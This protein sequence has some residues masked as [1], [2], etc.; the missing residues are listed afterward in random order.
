MVHGHEP[1]RFTEF[2]RRYLAELRDAGHH[3]AAEHL[4][5]LATHNKLMLLADTKDVDHS[6]VLFSPSG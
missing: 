4:H 5:D 1:S 6:Q 3:E 2:R